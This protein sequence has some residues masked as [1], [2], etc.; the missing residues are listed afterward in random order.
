[1]NSERRIAGSLFLLLIAFAVGSAVSAEVIRTSE[2]STVVTV[3]PD[4]TYTYNYTVKNTSHAP[5]WIDEVIEVWPTIVDFEVPL[6][7]PSI[8]WDIGSPEEWAYEFISFDEYQ[9]RFGEPNPFSSPWVLH[10]Y[11]MFPAFD[12]GALSANGEGIV[13]GFKPIVPEGYNARWETNYYEP[14]TDGFIFTSNL[15]PVNGPYLASW[16]DEERNIG[17]PPLPGGAVGGGGTPPFHPVPEPATWFLFG[18]GLAG[19]IGFG[20]KRLFQSPSG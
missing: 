18:S 9:M 1:M 15:P 19:I 10:W 17:D 2:V 7:H 12:R 5:Q 11:T 8:V 13:T 4:G 3:N 14:E 16:W 6:D 20:K